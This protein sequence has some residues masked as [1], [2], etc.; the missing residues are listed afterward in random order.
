MKENTVIDILNFYARSP[1]KDEM[2]VGR[3]CRYL[4]EEAEEALKI[5]TLE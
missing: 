5:L 1:N 4:Y 2:E 3:T